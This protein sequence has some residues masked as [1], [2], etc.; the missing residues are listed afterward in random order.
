MPRAR[1][2]RIDPT[3]IL[4]S[5]I[6]QSEVPS[7]LQVKKIARYQKCSREY[8]RRRR[9]VWVTVTT[10]LH[11]STRSPRASS[12]S[13]VQLVDI[14][15]LHELLFRTLRPDFPR[16]DNPPSMDVIGPSPLQS[17]ISDHICRGDG[18]CIGTAEAARPKMRVRCPQMLSNF[19]PKVPHVGRLKNEDENSK[20]L[21][22]AKDDAVHE[23][24]FD[25]RNQNARRVP[26]GEMA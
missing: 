25:P 22:L 19:V 10:R 4:L 7:I 24:W 2:R 23:S 16:V 21:C 11:R 9:L 1:L 3:R 18:W 13:H 26:G 17:R 8:H 12:S 14:S 20:S 5:R 6:V 15:S